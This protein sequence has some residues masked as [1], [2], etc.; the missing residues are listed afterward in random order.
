MTN[1]FILKLEQ[2]AEMTDEDR[3]ALETTVRD[4]RQI[5]AHQDLIREGDD[6]KDVHVILEG[7][8]VRYQLRGD[9][10]ITLKGKRLTMPDVQRMKEFAEFEPNYLHLKKRAAGNRAE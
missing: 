3:A 10:L 1:P 7:F 4:V 2:G 6:P 9:G 8:A 5:G